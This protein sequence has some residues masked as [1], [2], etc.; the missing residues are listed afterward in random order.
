MYTTL[1]N[2]IIYIDPTAN[3]HQFKAVLVINY[4]CKFEHIK[5]DT[6]M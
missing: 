1:Y 2:L 6:N 3:K 4:T 5:V